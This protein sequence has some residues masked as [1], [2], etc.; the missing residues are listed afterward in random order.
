MKESKRNAKMSIK[1][2]PKDMKIFR[3]KMPDKSLT[4]TGKKTISRGARVEMPSR[5]CKP[6]VHP[7]SVHRVLSVTRYPHI[8]EPPGSFRSLLGGPALTRYV[9]ECAGQRRAMNP[10]SPNL[11]RRSTSNSKEPWSSSNGS[12]RC[13]GSAQIPSPTTG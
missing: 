5:V 13:R 3:K 12:P 9:A 4:C 10:L 1:V 11:T 6:G 2:N 7:R 8:A